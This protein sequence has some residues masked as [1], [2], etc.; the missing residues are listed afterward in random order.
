MLFSV[1]LSCSGVK[2]NQQLSEVSGQVLTRAQQIMGPSN[3]DINQILACYESFDNR[4]IFDQNRPL[5]VL[6]VPNQNGSYLAILPKQENGTF[7]LPDLQSGSME[8]RYFDD[9]RPVRRGFP[10][11]TFEPT[12]WY[13]SLSNGGLNN[14]ML[15]LTPNQIEHGLFL[16]GRL[17]TNFRSIDSTFYG[18]PV[19]CY[20]FKNPTI[21]KDLYQT[22]F[23]YTPVKA[24]D[25][26]PNKMV[27]KNFSI[28]IDA[29][30]KDEKSDEHFILSMMDLNKG[31]ISL[32]GRAV[33]DSDFKLVGFVETDQ[34]QYFWK[35]SI[36][37]IFNTKVKFDNFF[38]NSRNL[39]R[40]TANCQEVS[41]FVSPLAQEAICKLALEK[42]TT[43]YKNKLNSNGFDLVKALDFGRPICQKE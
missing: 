34:D 24:T 36:R 23:V 32:Q 3:F 26:Q 4:K 43:D 27:L 35:L 2:K 42:G 20:T 22:L 31:A 19:V 18:H 7:S 13:T 17:F 12:Y 41:V 11:P 1:L 10:L 25:L 16:N 21:R 40:L 8:I 39:I 37:S 5:S 14:F 28:P 38:G 29:S 9:L 6:V 30:I 15:R 33:F